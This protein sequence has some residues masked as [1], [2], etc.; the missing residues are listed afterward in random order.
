[1]RVQNELEAI[2]N[3]TL[4]AGGLDEGAVR[5]A[6]Q[7][8]SQ[9]LGWSHPN[10]D[11]D[12][13]AI[14]SDDA[15][16][17]EATL[18]LRGSD[19]W[20]Y[21]VPLGGASACSYSVLAGFRDV[22][23][24]V[25]QQRFD[26]ELWPVS[27]IEVLISRFKVPPVLPAQWWMDDERELLA[28]LSIGRPIV[29]ATEHLR[30]ASEIHDSS[31][32]HHLVFVALAETDGFL[33]DVTGLLEKGDLHSAR[34]AAQLAL[35]Y[36]LD[37]AGYASGRSSGSAKW[38]WKRLLEYEDAGWYRR[39]LNVWTAARGVS[40]SDVVAWIQEARTAAQMVQLAIDLEQVGS[41]RALAE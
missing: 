40:D 39:A 27:A 29:G 20:R 7:T 32:L 2:F 26:L 16:E 9:V 24:Q 17:R 21:D 3:D 10:S 37:G 6:Y 22:P 38:R 28:R 34:D 8:G 30:L 11:L 13:V 23:G 14:V 4:R 12:L 31:F 1:M 33:E 35:A 41:D 25:K 15:F 18:P 36:A 19:V 5:T